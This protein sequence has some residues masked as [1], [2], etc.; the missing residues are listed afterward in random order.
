MDKRDQ[1]IEKLRNIA[2][3]TPEND[4]EVPE[5]V[6]GF[7]TIEYSAQTCTACKKCILAN[8]EPSRLL[9]GY[10]STRRFQVQEP[11]IARDPSATTE[12]RRRCNGHLGS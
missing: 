4:V 2:V 7:G 5:K 9:D 6:E 12:A 3:K 10:N 1:L 8:D 11:R